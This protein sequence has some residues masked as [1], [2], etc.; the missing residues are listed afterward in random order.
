MPIVPML[1][2]YFLTT[3]PLSMTEEERAKFPKSKPR[4]SSPAARKAP[5]WGWFKDRSC[6]Y[7]DSFLHDPKDAPS[8]A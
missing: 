5:C 6:K 2:D 8:G 7:G 1:S 3:S 4:S